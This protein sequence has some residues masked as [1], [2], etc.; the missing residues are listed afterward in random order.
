MRRRELC[1]ALSLSV[2]GGLVGLAP[3]ALLPAF[4]QQKRALD[5]QLLG[6][7]LGTQVPANAAVFEIMPQMFGYAPPNI[8]RLDQVRVITQTLIGE[9]AEIGSADLPTSLSAAEAGAKLKVVGKLYDKTTHVFVANADKIKSFEDLIRPDVRVSVGIRG[10]VSQIMLF[11][12]LRKRGI[13]ANKATNIEMPGSGSRM[14]ALLAGR[15]D[16]TYMHFDQFASI[17]GK[18]NFQILIR[19]WSEFP[20]WW[21]ETWIVRAQWLEDP[22]NERALVDLLKANIIAFRKANTDFDWYLQM[23]RKYSSLKGAKTVTEAELRPN[24]EY[25]RNDIKAWPN[26][27]KFTLAEAKQLIPAYIG[28][29]AIRGTAKLEDVVEPKY[30]EQALRELG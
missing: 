25:V 14:N 3:F 21:H 4:A 8:A 10:E 1:K 19:P 13:D 22:Q 20:A 11:E 28:A 27:M 29:D 24:W 30:V 26:D 17:A 2:G 6:F 5:M 12:P 23:Y 18:G 9:S 7:V 16:A 15:I